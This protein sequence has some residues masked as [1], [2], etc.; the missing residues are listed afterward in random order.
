LFFEPLVRT[1]FVI[2]L[3]VVLAVTAW[4]TASTQQASPVAGDAA[5]SAAALAQLAPADR[6]Q[7]PQPLARIEPGTRIGAGPPAGWSR[8]V[9]KSRPKVTS[10]DIDKV[11]AV[12]LRMANKYSTS[13]LVQVEPDPAKQGS[14]RLGQVAVGLGVAA[15]SD[16]VIVTK[17]RAADLGIHLGLI[18]GM[19]LS[20]SEKQLDKVVQVARTSTMA[21]V[22][23]PSVLLR[24][25]QHVES[26]LRHVYLVDPRDGAVHALLWVLDKVPEGYRFSGDA[27]L[28]L[29]PDQVVDCE[30][31]VD[32]S[33]FFLGSP[34]A[35]AFAASNLPQGTPLAMPEDAKAAAAAT[36][37]SANSAYQLELRLWNILF[38]AKP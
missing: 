31:H 12:T 2:T 3:F 11:A 38:P 28:E 34:G 20:E 22:D 26:V 13:I 16:D 30:L 27:L 32:S 7:A 29:K 18:E 19:V 6:P 33:K 35:D 23:F 15:E 5:A 9:M 21:I 14:A 10:G 25:N 8:L 24:G 36:K 1:A 37:F 17:A 4:R